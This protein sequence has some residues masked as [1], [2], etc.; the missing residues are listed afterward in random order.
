MGDDD[1]QRLIRFAGV[2][3]KRCEYL[4]H[5][6]EPCEGGV[7]FRHGRTKYHT[8]AR[9]NSFDD[10]NREVMLCDRH[11]EMYDDHWDAMWAE[12]PRG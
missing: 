10:P 7:K 8:W 4:D 2:L 12:V 5:P 1:V 6:D 3:A 11:A 9:S